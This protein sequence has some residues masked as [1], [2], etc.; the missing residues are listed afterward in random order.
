MPTHDIIV[1]GGSAGSVE[2]LVKLA[3]QLSPDL[4]AAVFITVHT[5]PNTPSLLPQIL[6]RAGDLPAELARD[7]E[8][9]KPGRIYLPPPDHHLLFEDGIIRVV[10]GP[11]ENGH[12]PAVD[13]M[14]RSAA[15]NF[16]RRVIGVVISG[17]LDD[18]TA[19]LLAIKKQGGIA[20]VQ[21]PN[22]ALFPGMPASAVENVDVDHVV[23]LSEIAPILNR[24]AREPVTEPPAPVPEE[25]MKEADIARLDEAAMM[26]RDR[27][28]EPSGL[29]CP[30]CNGVLFEIKDG[31]N[32]RYRCRVGH[33][34]SMETLFSDQA[35][36]V[37]AALWSAMVALKEKAVLSRR[38]MEYMRQR[39]HRVS[40]ARFEEHVKDAEQQAKL[41]QDVL[42]SGAANG[43]GEPLLAGEPAGAR[44]RTQ[45]QPG[46]VKARGG[47]QTT[48]T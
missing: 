9:I 10:R 5:T 13:P 48:Q 47:G 43:N 38:M 7:G 14:F 29:T 19:G 35:Q 24:L 3:P 17:M 26:A 15:V 37:E 46:P 30:E 32:A 22:E 2:A 28:G 21:D 16:G 8:R 11:K 23:L 4:P 18:G 20:V 25:M 44:G 1:I 36:S 27:P 6:T 42:E 45:A 34:Y 33:A 12:R 41:I 39:G 40:T 31:E